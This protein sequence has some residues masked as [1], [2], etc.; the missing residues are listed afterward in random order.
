MKT[1][2]IIVGLCSF[3]FAV[4]FAWNSYD[5]YQTCKTHKCHSPNGWDII[6]EP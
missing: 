2:L 3:G 6:V 5:I 4:Y 1:L